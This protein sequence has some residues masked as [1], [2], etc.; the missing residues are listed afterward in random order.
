MFLLDLLLDLLSALS[1]KQDDS[2]AS[3]AEKAADERMKDNRYYVWGSP[4][5][6]RMGTVE[7]GKY[8]Y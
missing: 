7:A 6:D 4:E 5:D 8:Q 2:S 1:E 3:D